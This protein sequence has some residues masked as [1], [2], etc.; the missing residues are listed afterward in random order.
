MGQPYPGTQAILRAI[1][2][3]KRFDDQ[4]P[5]WTLAE[6]T[7]ALD[8]NKTTVFRLLSAL[9]S[10]GLIAR[11]SSGE[12]YVLGPELVA[13]AGYA[14]RNIDL[15]SLARPTL[16]KLAETSGETASLEILSGDEMLIIDEIVGG[17][18]VSGVRSIGTRWP[19]HG[20]ST[21]LALLATW[22]P[23]QREAYLQRD[24]AAVTPHTI[25][26]PRALRNLLAK[27]SQQGYALSDE[28][29]EPDLVAIGA[30]VVNVD[31]FA[32]AAISIYGPKSRLNDRC[33]Q[34]MAAKVR[35][36]ASDISASLGYR[37][38]VYEQPQS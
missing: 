10:E 30:P 27:F 7:R 2:V 36:A 37:P 6:L 15:R 24:L 29:L 9:E 33:V 13:M 23:Q 8:L 38:L 19:L 31:G 3:L 32:E 26:D 16:E 20:T 14:L 17:H 4:H 21:G 35:Q 18:L 34:I 12:T 25:T 11:G 1:A 5:E 22:S 28:M